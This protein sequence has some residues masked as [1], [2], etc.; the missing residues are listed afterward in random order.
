M[1]MMIFPEGSLT[2]TT[3]VGGTRIPLTRSSLRA[4]A[5]RSGMIPAV[6]VYCVNP[7]SIA[8]LPASIIKC[9]MVL[10]SFFRLRLKSVRPPPRM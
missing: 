2:R 3:G 8:F 4:M 6:G 7:S 9:R 1:S 5:S 10:P